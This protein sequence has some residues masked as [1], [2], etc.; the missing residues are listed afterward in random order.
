MNNVDASMITYFK[1]NY[2]NDICDNLIKLWE[3]GC[4]K[5]KK[6]SIIIFQGKEK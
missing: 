6:K 2:E 5:E 3:R 1:A 4:K